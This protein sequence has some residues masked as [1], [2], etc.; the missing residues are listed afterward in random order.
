MEKILK[1]YKQSL[2]TDELDIE[3]SK[4]MI[5]QEIKGLNKKDLFKE[6]EKLTLWKKIKK[7]LNF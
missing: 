1:W 7:I 5:I 4:K 2:K 6:P 3:N